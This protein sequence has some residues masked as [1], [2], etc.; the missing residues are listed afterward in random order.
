MAIPVLSDVPAALRF[1]SRL[2]VPR[3]GSEGSIDSPP[4]I[5]R[6]GPAFP[7][8]AALIGVTGALAF[9]IGHWLNLGN[10]IS[11]TLAV[12]VLA[13]VTGALH[14][15]GL[16]DT[17]DALGGMNIPRRLEIMKDS[18]VGPFGVVALILSFALRIGA[19]AALASISMLGAAGAI[20]AAA[21]VSRL[22]ALWILHALPPARPT[23]L[24]SSA[25]RPS[26]N[27]LQKAASI[28][29]AIAAILVI[30]SFGILSLLAG[31]LLGIV[32]LFGLTRLADAQF[33][34]QTGDVAGAAVAVVEIAFLLGLLIFARPL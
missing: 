23:G 9:L 16:A 27:T 12:G 25:G 15:D 6:L 29:A 26:R 21:S 24:S 19:L 8:A 20:I 2:P 32:A 22:G 11:A 5:E 1:L 31:F 10:F 13:A 34:G 33:G 7:I 3:L 14:E 18:A 28:A 17:A 4:D 30:P